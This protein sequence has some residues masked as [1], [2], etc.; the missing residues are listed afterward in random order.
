MHVCLLGPAAPAR[1]VPVVSQVSTGIKPADDNY[2]PSVVAL[3]QALIDAGHRVTVVTHRRGQPAVTLRGAGV[4]FIQ[5]DSRRRAR[6]QA[7]DWWRAERNSMALAA[8]TSGA[9]VVHA[10]WSYE[11]A[12]A[13]LESGLPLVV[14]VHDAPLTVVAHNPDPYRILRLMLAWHVRWRLRSKTRL[15]APSPYLAQA[16]KRQMLWRGPVKVLPNISDAPVNIHRQP[17]PSPLVIEV[18]NGDRLKNVK[19]LLRAFADVRTS[20]HQARLTLIGPELGV[21]GSIRGWASKRQLDDGVDFRGPLSREQTAREMAQAWVHAHASREESFGMTI[22]EAMTLGV[23]VIAGKR[24]GAAPWLLDHGRAGVLTRVGSPKKFAAALIALLE[25]A[26]LREH[27]SQESRDRAAREFGSSP[28]AA[29]HVA[30]YEEAM[31]TR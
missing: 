30:L 7:L 22:L 8:A 25:D 27:L 20:I 12:L 10:H 15:I 26:P 5:V 13:G 17:A 14:T 9:D 28:I 2:G 6:E 3:A 18:S 11:W 21:G 4:D 29:A 1:L 19:S 23:P 24:A 16:W 31:G